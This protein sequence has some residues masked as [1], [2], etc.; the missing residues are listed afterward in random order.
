MPAAVPEE[1]VCDWRRLPRRELEDMT[2]AA[3][4]ICECWRLMRKSGD[5]VVSEFLRGQ[6]SLLAWKHYPAGDAYDPETHAQYFYHTHSLAEPRD[7]HGHFHTFLR[8]AGIPAGMRPVFTPPAADGGDRLSHLIGIA[9]D[10]HGQPL[11]LFTTNGWVTGEV[12]YA[13]D[14]VIAL[15]DRFVVDMAYP[16]L[17]VNVWITALLRLFRPEI[18]GLLH[19]RDRAIA[20]WQGRHPDR[21]V[22]AGAELEIPSSLDI[23]IVR[24][25]ADLQ[26]IVGSL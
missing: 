6:G 11:R 12:L 4:Q 22:Y 2:A 9:M 1:S 10:A 26:A 23:A 14:D 13:A 16:S 17:T 19:A 15:L 7:E 20:D 24:R 21:D 8:A 18:E 3:G 25:I 5:T